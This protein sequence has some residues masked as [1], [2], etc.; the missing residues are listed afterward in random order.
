MQN[1][2]NK[3][4]LPLELCVCE[5]ISKEV[6]KSKIYTMKKRFGKLST[7]IVGLDEKNIDIKSLVSKMKSKLA[8]GGTY[9]NGKIELQ[10]KHVSDVKKIL[11]DEGFEE[12]SITVTG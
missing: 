9:K 8:C 7:L 1:I 11:V 12:K 10:G 2:C 4:G 5:T 6:Q 3:C